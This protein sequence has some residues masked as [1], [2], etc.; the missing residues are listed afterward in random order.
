[1]STHGPRW[2]N[3]QVERTLA[4][5]FGLVRAR[6]DF[7]AAAAYF[8]V[9]PA[10][11]RRWVHGSRRAKSVIPV[12]RLAQLR[13][14]AP[15]ILDQEDSRAA[16]AAAAL[17]RI[18]TAGPRQIWLAPGPGNPNGRDWLAPYLVVVLAPEPN[19]HQIATRRV[20]SQRGVTELARAAGWRQ[21]AVM[22]THFHAVLLQHAVLTQVMPWR[23]RA[24]AAVKTGET[25]CWEVAGSRP[26]VDL[27]AVSATV[28]GQWPWPPE[29]SA[30]AQ[31]T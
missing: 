11:V 7:A 22:P 20:T 21:A 12:K 13:L 26:T 6:P 24:S 8:S 25:Q 5:R 15:D 31:A 4:D 28:I 1:M 14:P 2:T 19:L 9:T 18:A 16:D 27:L 30:P 3:A 23:T 17:Q 29:G 10:S